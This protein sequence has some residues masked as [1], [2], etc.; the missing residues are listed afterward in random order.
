M[1]AFATSTVAQWATA[2]GAAVVAFELRQTQRALRAR[3]ERTFVKRYERIAADIP[4]AAL[5][6]GTLSEEESPEEWEKQLRA[7]FD[8]FEL[9]EEELYYRSLGRI[10]RRTWKDWWEGIAL[11]LRSDAFQ[12]ALGELVARSGSVRDENRDRPTRYDLTPR[13]R[14]LAVRSR[15]GDPVQGWWRQRVKSSTW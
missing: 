13:A 5:L 14:D 3:F 7:F 4:L 15:T 6:D 2:V 10:S 11:N 8:Y 1:I 12:E 9:C